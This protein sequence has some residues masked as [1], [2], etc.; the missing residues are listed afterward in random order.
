MMRIDITRTTEFATDCKHMFIVCHGD[1][2][3]ECN[4]Q[5]KTVLRFDSILIEEGDVL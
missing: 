1:F 2:R 5:T 3:I 4:Y